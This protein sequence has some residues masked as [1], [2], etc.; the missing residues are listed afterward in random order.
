MRRELAALGN[1]PRFEAH[2]QGSGAVAQGPNSAAAG[3]GGFA[4][5]GTIRDSIIF[6][7]PVYTGS[8]TR[9]PAEAL[10]MY[11]QEVVKEER[12]LSLRG[13][14]VGASDAIT[15]GRASDFA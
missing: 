3:E 2:L 6:T 9:D 8:P 7:G 10:M 1:L 14:D 12:Y 13:L 15:R 5:T 11:Y 4:N